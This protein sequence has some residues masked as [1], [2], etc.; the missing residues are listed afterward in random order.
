[1]TTQDKVF[2][3]FNFISIST[4]TNIVFIVSPESRL[5]LCLFRWLNWILRRVRSLT[6]NGPYIDNIL[7]S[8]FSSNLIKF[9][10]AQT[11][12]EFLISTV[13]LFHS[14]MQYGKKLFLKDFVL[15]KE[16]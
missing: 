7:E 11:E 12:F 8:S 14:F 15:D 10:K 1:M 6:Q 16:G 5:N 3:S 13:I 2:T 4:S 9:F